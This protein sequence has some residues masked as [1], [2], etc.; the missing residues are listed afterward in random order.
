MRRWTL[1]VATAASLALPAA[2]NGESA[3]QLADLLARPHHS[4][5][6]SAPDAGRFA[7]VENRLGARNVWVASTGA[8]ASQVTRFGEDDGQDVSQLRFSADGKGLVFVR[9]SPPGPDGAA[10]DPLSTPGGAKAEMIWTWK[11][12]GAAAPY[13]PGSS[14][15]FSPD[16]SSLAFVRQGRLFVGPLSEPEKA[17]GVQLRGRARTPA[18]SPSGSAVAF[19]SDRGDH[20]LVGVYSLDAKSVT[21]MAPGFGTDRAPAWSPDGSRIAF[22]RMPS[23]PVKPVLSWEPGGTLEVWV[24]EVRTG[25]GARAFRS[26]DRNAGW[27][28]DTER[29]PLLWAAGDRLVFPW[30][31]DGWARFYAVAASGGG[32]VALTPPGCEAR[33]AALS[34]A[35]DALLFASNCGDPDRSHVWTVP[36]SGGEAHLLTPGKGIEVDPV[37]SGNAVAFFSGDAQRPLAPYVL[38]RGSRPRPLPQGSSSD[39]P[40]HRLVEPEP[41]ELRAADGTV[42]HG[43]LFRPADGHPGRRPAIVFVHGGPS[44]QMLL[45]WHPT[46]WY[47]FAYALNQVLVAKGFVV[48]SVNYRGGT[49]Y[50]RRFRHPP[51]LGPEGAVE[52]QDVP[53][54]AAWLRTRDFVDPRRI[55]IWG[56]SYGG[57]LTAMALA[58]HPALF[59]AGFDLAGLHDWPAFYRTV[60]PVPLGPA[61]VKRAA[62]SS[63]VAD[64]S[65]W[66]APVLVVHGDC[67]GAVPFSQSLDLI[68]RLQLLPRPPEVEMLAIP[69]EVHMFLRY[70]TWSRVHRAAADFFERRLR[71]RFLTDH[72]T[73]AGEAK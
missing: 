71:S 38:E 28:Q 49:G 11:E 55:G 60:A 33:G 66:R 45:G 22:L 51:G 20:A 21:W 9:G 68:Q 19:V 4:G 24:A 10:P 47:H 36:V 23:D 26:K 12:G 63:P 72:P 43:Q 5:L 50:G 25:N 41:V 65:R 37:A 13:A 56:G 8:G 57:L 62:S 34:P 32:P 52:Y 35:R 44:R 15:A 27:A 30:E 73:D 17:V 42:L 14:P 1:A 6:V 3:S 31:G 54:A 2:A 40:A 58:R 70:D 59:A 7:W 48:L 18:W 69:D 67:D 46:G 64:L 16:G 61:E 53:A 29:E 39:V